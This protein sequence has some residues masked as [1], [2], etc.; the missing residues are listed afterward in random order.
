M[1]GTREKDHHMPSVIIQSNALTL[2]LSDD[3]VDLIVTSPPY[4]DADAVELL[5]PHK[6][7]LKAS[8]HI[9]VPTRLLS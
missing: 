5:R 2:P 4:S 7:P 3:T 1:R 8:R 6:A 9:S